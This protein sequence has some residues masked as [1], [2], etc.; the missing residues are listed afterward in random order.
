MANRLHNA[1]SVDS[2]VAT[3]QSALVLDKTRP[4][5]KPDCPAGFC[6]PIEGKP[7]D[8][9][10]ATIR[11]PDCRHEVFVQPRVRECSPRCL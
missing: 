2:T 3:A 6:G 4:S 10:F 11:R 8:R 1:E 7:T 5:R 9:E